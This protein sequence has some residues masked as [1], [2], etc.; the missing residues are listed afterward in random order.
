MWWAFARLSAAMGLPLP[1]GVEELLGRAGDA[2]A[3]DVVLAQSASRAR[4]SWDEIR[5]SPHGV[6]AGDAPAPGWLVPDRLPRGRLDLAPVPLV[7]QLETWMVGGDRT[8]ADRDGR[9]RLV[10]RRLPHQMNSL[11]RNTEGQQ[12]APHP[13]LL[14]HPADAE[15][16]GVRDGDLVC[17]ASVSTSASGGASGS[18]STEATAQCTSEIRQ[19]T[20]SLPHGWSRPFVNALTSTVDDVDPLTGMPLYSNL[21]VSVSVKGSSR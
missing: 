16:N 19:G 2:E 20:V 1:D 14:M 17:V 18:A 11:L 7:E 4:L 5:S 13:T 8:P 9:L 10:N 3:D 15:A 12:R 21:A 6:L